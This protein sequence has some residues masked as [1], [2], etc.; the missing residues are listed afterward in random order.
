MNKERETE[1]RGMEREWHAP[2]RSPKIRPMPEVEGRS[3]DNMLSEGSD[4]VWRVSA[5]ERYG[6]KD[7]RRKERATLR[8]QR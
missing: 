4:V 6:A 7:G 2:I 1:E 5:H 3:P 8:G